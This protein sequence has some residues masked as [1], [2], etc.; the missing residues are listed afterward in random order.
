MPKAVI[1]PERKDAVIAGLKKGLTLK[2]ACEKAG[3]SH[4]PL[5][6]W[7]KFVKIA[8]DEEADLYAELIG[9]LSMSRGL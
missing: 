6:D 5:V 2:T 1:A 8:D 4:L 3:I 9:Y 7:K